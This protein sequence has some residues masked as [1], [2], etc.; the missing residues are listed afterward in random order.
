MSGEGSR[1]GM[2]SALI[3]AASLDGMP[4]LATMAAIRE[5]RLN[6]TPPAIGA[7]GRPTLV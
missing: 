3:K 7:V 1:Q 2:V 6:V 5:G 4:T